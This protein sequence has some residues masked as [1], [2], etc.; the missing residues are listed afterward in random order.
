MA[1]TPRLRRARL[2]FGTFLVQLAD[3]RLR[4][5][6]A[7][8]VSGLIAAGAELVAHITIGGQRAGVHATVD[9][10]SVGAFAMLASAG[11]L[12]ATRERRKLV[13]HE[14]E[15]VAQ[16]NHEIRNALQI[17]MHS[18]YGEGSEHAAMVLESVQRI[19]KTLK[20]LFP[21]VEP[22]KQKTEELERGRKE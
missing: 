20:T 1:G 5:A 19:E 21:G 12:S 14:M 10:S 9:A 3:S 6:A 4:I 17:I 11:L 8:I 2:A 13:L 16:L 18:H 7:T 22:P 15:R